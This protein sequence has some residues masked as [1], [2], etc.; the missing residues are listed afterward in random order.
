MKKNQNQYLRE[1]NSKKELKFNLSS[2][3]FL[4]TNS[5]NHNFITITD[6][7]SPDPSPMAV[8][9]NVRAISSGYNWFFTIFWIV[10]ISTK[11]HKPSL[12][13]IRYLWLSRIYT[14]LTSGLAVNPIFFFKDMSPNARVIAKRPP[15]LP[16]SIFPPACLS[17]KSYT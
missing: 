2:D 14:F 15:N 9:I 13:T 12:A 4:H 5:I 10:F 7:L 16:I 3:Y 8:L 11:S 1:I 17:K 6:I